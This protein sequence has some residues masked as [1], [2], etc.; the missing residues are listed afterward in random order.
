MYIP[1]MTFEIIDIEAA[2]I[3]VAIIA[4]TPRI[5][6]TG[7]PKEVKTPRTIE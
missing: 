4:V 7:I 1:A 2:A 5:N 3:A 6:S